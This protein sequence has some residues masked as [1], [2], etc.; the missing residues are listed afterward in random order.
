MRYL[1]KGSRFKFRDGDLIMVR[2][3]AGHAT[4]G[5]PTK[6]VCKVLLDK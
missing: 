6:K 5:Q 1:A 2:F 3:F 4:E